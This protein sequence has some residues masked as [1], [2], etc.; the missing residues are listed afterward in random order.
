MGS[1][2]L[3]LMIAFACTAVSAGSVQAQTAT[4]GEAQFRQRC[5][6][7]HTVDPARRHG[8]GPNLSGVMNRAPAT[9]TGYNYSQGMRA[10]TT[11]WTPQTLDG[12]LAAPSRAV[13]GTRMTLGVAN[14]ADRAAI[15]AYL[16]TR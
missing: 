9:A 10:L 16:R 15:V 14:A 11:G 5:G 6:S 7:C 13:P 4:P 1:T 3:A 2:R 8:V 12:F